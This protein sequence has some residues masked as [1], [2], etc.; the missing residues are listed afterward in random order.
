MSQV[1]EST[2]DNINLVSTQMQGRLEEFEEL[3]NDQENRRKKRDFMQQFKNEGGEGGSFLEI[4]KSKSRDNRNPKSKQ[5]ST[6]RNT[7]RIKSMTS[8]MEDAYSKG[9]DF[10]DFKTS[11]P[12]LKNDYVQLSIF[13]YF[14]GHKETI[15]NILKRIESVEDQ[16]LE[17]ES[18]FKDSN[19]EEARILYSKNEWADIIKNIKLKFPSLSAKTKKSLKYITN[20]IQFQTQPQGNL[21][22]NQVDSIWSQASAPP[23]NGLTDEDLK[24]LYDLSHEQIFNDNTILEDDLEDDND[25][26]NPFVLTLSQAMNKTEPLEDVD[27]DIISDSSPEPSQLIIGSR[28]MD[29]NSLNKIQVKDSIYNPNFHIDEISSHQ[30][31]SMLETNGSIDSFPF[32]Q[33]IRKRSEN[34]DVIEIPHPHLKTTPRNIEPMA[35]TQDLPIN[36]SSST[37]DQLENEIRKGEQLSPVLPD[38]IIVSSPLKDAIPEVFKTPTKRLQG[39]SQ[40]RSS[41]LSLERIQTPSKFEGRAS[42]NFPEQDIVTSSNV[43]SL[44]STAKS[45]FRH[46]AEQHLESQSDSEECGGEEIIFSS[47]PQ[48]KPKGQIKSYHTSRL[49]VR[50]GL[51][52]AESEAEYNKVKIKRIETKT[53]DVDSENEI[54]DSQEENVNDH[55]V[56]II[57]ITRELNDTEELLHLGQSPFVGN[58][59]TEQDTSVLQVPSSPQANETGILDFLPGS[60]SINDVFSSGIQSTQVPIASETSEKNGLD[61][62]STKYLRN[63]LQEWG[64]KPVKGRDRMIQVLSKT[65]ALID[66]NPFNLDKDEKTPIN[67]SQYVKTSIYNKIN[68]AIKQDQYWLDKVISFEPINLG[69]LHQWLGSNPVGIELE[70]DTLVKYCDDLGIACT[71]IQ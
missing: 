40:I 27:T 41:P 4:R 1:P 71:D 64:L 45:R 70:R 30:R 38:E 31:E 33:S 68:E 51:C 34:Q 52:F 50:G 15:S 16:N 26:T 24:W 35:G 28:N 58:E 62:I 5:K 37:H 53:I 2:G 12:G 29:K 43:S 55:S 59:R 21:H 7:K 8:L 18:L 67:P 65:G 22:G 57:E 32:A 46:T 69:R 44:Y 19:R 47:M 20:K 36:I 13:Q 3:G 9:K 23:D 17:K 11:E 54:Y 42:I 66:E 63:K 49:E 14:S 48:R 6:K 60:Q 61:K 56:S 39:T 10:Q 25:S